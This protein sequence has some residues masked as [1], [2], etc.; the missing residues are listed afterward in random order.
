MKQHRPKLLVIGLDAASY[1]YLDPWFASGEL[2]HLSALFKRSA[3]GT[4][5]STVPPVTSVAWTSM[6]T[7]LDPGQLGIYDMVGH[8]PGSYNFLP[9]TFLNTHH[10]AI[11]DLLSGKGLKSAVVGVP[12][13]YP[14]HPI[15]GVLITGFDSP[16][17]GNAHT[18]PADW[19]QEL[20][21]HNLR[22]PW[23]TLDKLLKMENHRQVGQIMD[24]YIACWREIT[25]AKAAITRHVWQES[26]PDFCMVV[27]SSTDHIVHHAASRDDVLRV[28]RDVDQAIGHILESVDQENTWVM[29]TSDHGSLE[30]DYL[31]SIYRLLHDHGWISFRD[32]VALEN[33]RWLVR[34]VAPRFAAP[35]AKF[36]E[37]APV[38]L[39]RLLSWPVIYVEPRLQ[40]SY[41]NIDWS[42]T[43]VFARDSHGPLY[44]N[45]RGR[46]PQGCVEPG[47]PY[48]QLRSTIIAA[49]ENT[50]DPQTGQP[51][52]A[53][54]QRGEMVYRPPY[55][56]PPPD[57][58]FEPADWKYKFVM[59]FH[60]H[61]LVRPNRHDAHH[62]VEHG[63]H[64]PWGIFAIAGPEVQ[65][66]RLREAAIADIAPTV[67]HLLAQPLPDDLAGKPIESAL[68]P[69]WQEAHP[70]QYETYTPVQP[71]G[72][73][74][75]T[76][77]EVAVIEDRLRTLGYL[78]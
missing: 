38:L 51:L 27:F 62:Y 56:A 45:V 31:V 4:L 44:L 43:A 14:A 55:A 67:L 23:E 40:S 37:W 75:A 48:E 12:S 49:M 63:W 13:T 34:R 15:N 72:T 60:T 65:P 21:A 74:V 39:R 71:S 68:S 33:L 78:E 11:W 59:G 7:G 57:L 18:Y 6:T 20:T 70:V 77:E 1:N 76:E 26:E 9:A 5:R 32:E 61:A 50:Q 69:A 58:V 36:W 2:P 46:E 35:L 30:T 22:F 52:F 10:R 47:E 42:R 19:A 64:T 73:A 54:V 25:Q 66:G 24:T 3:Y 53:W 16:I 17:N 8:C 28:Y 29:L 41:G